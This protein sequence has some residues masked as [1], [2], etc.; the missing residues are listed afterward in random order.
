MLVFSRNRR[1]KAYSFL[2]YLLIL[3]L[4]CIPVGILTCSTPAGQRQPAGKSGMLID[5]HNHLVGQ[6]R[7]RSGPASD[8]EGAARIT[9]A[10]MNELGIKKMIIMPPP[11]SPN[12]HGIYDLEHL[13]DI[14]RKYPDRF[15]FL[16]GGET[17]NVIIQEAVHDGRTSSLQ[18]RRFIERAGEILAMGAVGFGE[19]A[20]EHL[21]LGRKHNYQSA[22]ADHPLFI[23]LAD[24]A[25]KNDVPIDIHMEAVPE[26]MPL[27]RR[28]RSPPNPEELSPNIKAFE[29]LL[30]HNP[31]AKI[32]WSH[33]GWDNTGHRTA[34]LTAR[35]LEAHPNLYM[36][37][38]ISP[39]DSLAET[40]PIERGRGLKAEW[41]KV[42]REF[43]DRFIIGSDQFYLSPKMRSQIGPRSVEPTNK[44]FS[45][46]PP[47]LARKI[48]Y[49]NP[50][51][52][53]NLKD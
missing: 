9:L 22:P 18:R 23:L 21:C 40:R 51:F 48:G 25:A 7:S 3:T 6:F 5:A 15:A 12:H 44:F 43:A 11:F 42:I 30:A 38:K 53:F 17:L 49:D 47:D 10:K 32:L 24:I 36:S 8:Y 4:A 39:R 2:P 16:G 31:K 41:L 35:L 14:V 37:F 52:I 33:I 28:L 27:P 46:L 19:F 45:L 34:A 26:P 13:A 20:I 50:K 1:T 29:R